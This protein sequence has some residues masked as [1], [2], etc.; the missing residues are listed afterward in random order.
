VHRIKTNRKRKRSTD[1]CI[2][3][4][5]V[6]TLRPPQCFKILSKEGKSYLNRQKCCVFCRVVID[7][8]PATFDEAW[9]HED[10]KLE[11]NGKTPFKMNLTI[12]MSNKVGRS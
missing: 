8:E 6:S 2:G 3:Q 4:K 7:E 12:L 5:T 1:Q 10:Q 11:E 9:N